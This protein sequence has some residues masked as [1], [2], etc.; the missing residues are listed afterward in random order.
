MSICHA[1]PDHPTREHGLTLRRT[2]KARRYDERSGSPSQRLAPGHESKKRA[3]TISVLSGLGVQ[4]PEK[5]F[6]PPSPT[7]G[8]YSPSAQNAKRPSKL[9][10]FFGQRPPSEL[11]T[12]HL[13][14]YFPFTE[15]K[16]LERTARHSM[17]RSNTSAST[18]RES[19]A[20]FTPPVSSQSGNS[21]GQNVLTT[22]P[23]RNFFSS[24]APQVPDKHSQTDNESVISS[25][26]DIPRMS[27][28]TDDGRSV[29]LHPDPFPSISQPQLLPPIP[30]PKESFSE[31]LEG[32]TGS[33][34]QRAYRPISRVMSIA[35]RRMS[36]MTELRS[37]RDQSDTASLMTVDEITAE[38]ESRR[39]SQALD[40][41]SDF[42]DW[43]KLDTPGDVEDASETLVDDDPE[44]QVDVEDEDEGTTFNYEEEEEGKGEPTI[45]RKGKHLFIRQ[46]LPVSHFRDSKQVDQRRS[47][48][49]RIFWQSLP[50]IRCV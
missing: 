13:T 19:G 48:W 10:N 6:D 17:M 27:L 1:S 42:D 49:C 8:R 7:S 50:R 4:N 45:T 20:S 37:K 2:N 22:S 33:S 14:E 5:A 31:S 24:L 36:Y 11:I 35:S 12:N 18:R 41:T 21:Q 15:K 28:S 44:E 29:D 30:I 40:R 34:G 9:R 16:V 26:E 46:I 32:I 25:G 23:T 39:V 3:S 43:T 47:H 38:V